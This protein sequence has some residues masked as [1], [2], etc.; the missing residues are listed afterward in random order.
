MAEDVY[1]FVNKH[2]TY[3]RV[4]QCLGCTSNKVVGEL[5]GFEFHF[6]DS[7]IFHD[8]EKTVGDWA[9]YVTKLGVDS[10]SPF[11][12]NK[13]QMY[14]PNLAY[15]YNVSMGKARM[16]RKSM[17]WGSSTY[18]TA[19]I[20]LPIPYTSI[21]ADITGPLDPLLATLSDSEGDEFKVFDANE[22]SE[23][24]R[25][26]YNLDEMD[27]LYTAQAADTEVNG[28]WGIGGRYLP[29]GVHIV[30]ATNSLPKAQST[31]EL[32]R[33]VTGYGFE[34]GT[35]GICKYII[36]DLDGLKVSY[37]QNDALSADNEILEEWEESIMDLH[38]EEL[39]MNKPYAWDRYLDTHIGIY[40]H[41][42]T[43]AECDSYI[44]ST[45]EVV[46]RYRETSDLRYA[47]RDSGGVHF[48]TAPYGLRTWE[49]N[50]FG[51]SSNFTQICGC[52]PSNSYNDLVEVEGI[53][54]CT[55]A[56]IQ[57]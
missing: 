48:Y 30:D 3:A 40:A 47:M 17:S 46:E 14:V 36:S 49:F 31:M 19:H 2:V 39:D 51:C 57:D 9:D 42:D 4:P 11:F 43:D 12:Y 25:L 29:L 18:D 23:L 37:W 27:V 35:S 10:P 55:G 1:E 52:M 45:T 7:D 56:A 16:L 8:N 22:C 15:H 32:V 38:N 41:G 44:S 26:P 53:T 33:D 6:V 50:A 13:V 20:Q 21:I 5:G 28:D 24:Q 54:V 34:I